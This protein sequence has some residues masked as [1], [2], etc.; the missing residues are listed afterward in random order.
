MIIVKYDPRMGTV[1]KIANALHHRRRTFDIPW[2]VFH[3]V[4]TVF[5]KSSV[6]LLHV[7]LHLF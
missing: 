4:I 1:T 5:K 6:V 2:V 3:T 7:L